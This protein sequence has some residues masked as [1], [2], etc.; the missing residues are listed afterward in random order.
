[1][2]IRASASDSVLFNDADYGHD[3]NFVLAETS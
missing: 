3:W 1:M 2:T